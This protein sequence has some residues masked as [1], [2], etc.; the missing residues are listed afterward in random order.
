RRGL[1]QGLD[2]ERCG[3]PAKY[4]SPLVLC[5]LEGRQQAEAARQ[6]NCSLSTLKRRLDDARELLHTRLLR[7]GITL[8]LALLAAAL[9]ESAG[10][11][12]TPLTMVAATINAALQW[13]ASKGSVGTVS[14]NVAAL[15]D[16]AV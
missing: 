8:P 15:V 16:A 3:L 2:E 1:L 11:A 10:T 7:R 5:Y 4:R 12:A 6:L 13:P 9:S 14:A